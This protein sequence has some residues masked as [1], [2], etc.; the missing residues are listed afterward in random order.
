MLE[1][2][3]SYFVRK[4]S[5]SGMPIFSPLLAVVVVVVVVEAGVPVVAVV[6][7]FLVVAV[8]LVLAVAELLLFDVVSVPPQPINRSAH[9]TQEVRKVFLSIRCSLRFRPAGSAQTTDG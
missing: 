4:S 2:Q 9:A 5:H 7:V 8:L 6:F 1:T 3:A